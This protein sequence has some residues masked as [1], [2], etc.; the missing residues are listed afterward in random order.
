MKLTTYIHALFMILFLCP[1]TVLAVPPQLGITGDWRVRVVHGDLRT[2]LDVA[3]P[4]IVSVTDEKKDKLPLYNE[5]GPMYRRGTPL[6]GVRAQECTVRGTILL[7]SVV[8]KDSPDGKVFAADKDYKIDDWG[9]IG[10]LEGGEIGED[11]SVVVSYQYAKMR[12]DSIVRNRDQLELRQG[13][14]HASLP[15]LPNLKEGDRRIANIWIDGPIK[16][17]SSDNLYP[18]LVDRYPEPERTEPSVAEQLLP[19][20]LK[21]LQDGEKVHILAWGDSVTD[22]GYLISKDYRWQERFVASLKHV[23]PK[24]D[25]QL[26]TVAWGGRNSASFLAEPE[27]SPYNYKEK[28]LNAK[29]DLI[30]ME[31]VNDSGLT[32]NPLFERYGKLLDDFNEIGSEWII[33][34]P[35]YV[36]PDWMALNSCKNCDNDPR[37]Y[38]HAIR[39]FGQEKKVAVADASKRWGHLWREGLPYVIL[40]TNNINHPDGSSMMLFVGALMELFPEKKLEEPTATETPEA[41]TMVETTEKVNDQNSAAPVQSEGEQPKP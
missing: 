32:E 15:R 2:R 1:A 36:R 22:A 41:K 33:L 34:T 30:V 35:H 18:I 21:K 23:F 38:V 20:T 7:D 13:E 4:E 24:A 8:V 25:I 27:G 37:L 3:P 17:L 19:K 12:L 40:L 10:R 5:E 6:Q 14:S 26:T 29:P 9:N 11:Q 16:F 28:I 31:F 39:K